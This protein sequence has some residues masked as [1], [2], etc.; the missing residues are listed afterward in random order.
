[1]R[2]ADRAAELETLLANFEAA[3]TEFY[4]REVSIRSTPAEQI[5][6][7]KSY[8]RWTYLPKI[9]AIA[10]AEPSDATALAASKWII[11]QAGPRGVG[12]QWK[13][14]F[15]AE[16]TAWRIIKE[17]RLPEEDISQLC[18]IAAQKRSPAREAFLRDMASRADLLGN[19]RAFATTALAKYLAQRFDECEADGSIAWWLKPKDEYF[20]FLRTQLAD[21]WIEYGTVADP[22]PFRREGIEL[23][24]RVLDEYA[25]VPVTM[26]ERY[27]PRDVTTLGQNAKQSRYALERLIVGAEAPDAMGRDLDGNPLRLS[28]YRGKVVLLSFWFTGCGPCLASI[29]E[30]QELVER[31]RDE[32]FALLGVCRDRDVAKSKQTAEEHGITWPCWFDGNPGAITDA[33][34]VTGFPTFYLL[35]AEGRI[36]SK[37]VPQGQLAEAVEAVIHPRTSEP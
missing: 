23:S 36:V 9:L 10:E 6:F 32:P 2:A 21:E 27:F 1:M 17:Q 18:M 29:P 7:Y 31:F 13:P 4:A 30:E 34:N 37:H 22:E 35:D 20:D 24:R 19:A 8:P 11:E 25:D 26:A 16:Q 5:A 14:L 12:N 15:A 3:Q 28:D 33:Y